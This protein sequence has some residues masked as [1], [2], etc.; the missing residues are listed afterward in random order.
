[1]AAGP[2]SVSSPKNYNAQTILNEV[3]K[4]V[5]YSK[6]KYSH[7][8][9]NINNY[10]RQLQTKSVIKAYSVIPFA[11][12]IVVNFQC[13]NDVRVYTHSYSTPPQSSSSPINNNNINSGNISENCPNNNKQKNSDDEAYDRAMSGL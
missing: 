9:K 2:I 13:Y 8:V 3:D 12:G 10:L 5:K 4:Y 1:M 7:L 11:P 6:H